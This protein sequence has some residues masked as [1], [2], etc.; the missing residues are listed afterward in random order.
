[1][2]DVFVA[3]RRPT[4]PG[5][6]VHVLNGCGFDLW[7]H[8]AGG[9]GVLAPDNVHLLP[10]DSQDYI[11]PDN[12]NAARITAYLSTPPADEIDKVEITI[13][14]RIVNYNITYVDWLGLPIEMRSFGT[15]S[16]CKV[17]GCYVPE[18]DVL[19]GC[20]AGLLSG[21]KCLS[22]GH[23][24][25]NGANQG[26]PFCHALDAKIAQCAQDPNT[27][28]APARREPRRRRRMGAAVS[29]AG[30]RSGARR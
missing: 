11:A 10:G 26:T 18:A 27:P 16:D 24:C 30:A 13:S 19:A 8:G 17:V 15:G 25:A 5:I 21:R 28:D 12:W 14:N 6:L 2:R 3:D 1:M 20:P 23:Y 9:G 29:S 7:V 4:D 22:A